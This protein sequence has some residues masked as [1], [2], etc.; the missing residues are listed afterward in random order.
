[1]IT[2]DD[3]GSPSGAGQTIEGA[4]ACHECGEYVTTA[5]LNRKSGILT[6][7]CSNGHKSE[8]EWNL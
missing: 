1:M 7:T 2:F 6:W 5:M 4:F 3:I 8:I